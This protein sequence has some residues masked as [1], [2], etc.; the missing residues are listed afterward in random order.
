MTPPNGDAEEAVP[1]CVVPVSGRE[2]AAVVIDRLPV[3][4]ARREV[5]PFVRDAAALEV[6]SGDFFRD[7]VRRVKVA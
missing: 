6:W 5:E 7:V 4:Q 3:E 2:E 1:V